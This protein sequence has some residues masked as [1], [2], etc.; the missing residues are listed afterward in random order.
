MSFSVASRLVA[1]R[2]CW[3]L[4]L[5][6][7]VLTQPAGS[8]LGSTLIK[9]D[10]DEL[11]TRSELVV[12]GQAEDVYVQWDNAQKM[13][14]TYVSV[15]VDEALK[16]TA[17]RSLLIRQLGG[18]VGAMQMRVPGTATFLEGDRVI[19]FLERR[20]DQTFQVVG[21]SQGKYQI[22]DDF[23]VS[24]LTGMNLVDPKTGESARPLFVESATLAGFKRRIQ[25][26][27]Q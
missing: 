12:E 27:V 26:L 23:V 24:N 18:Q 25:E 16:G 9:L 10:L 2:A 1:P 11:V 14:F 5:S 17:P 4:L 7:L 6:I 19:V 15:R 3:I 22:L 8:V 20:P 13:I 21:M